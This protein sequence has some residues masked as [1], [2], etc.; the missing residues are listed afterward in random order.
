MFEIDI[1]INTCDN[2]QIKKNTILKDIPLS[3]ITKSYIHNLIQ[4]WLSLKQE[5]RL[6]MNN[7]NLNSHLR[8]FS[9]YTP[10]VG[11]PVQ[12]IWHI[13]LCVGVMH[14]LA[15]LSGGHRGLNA[16]PF[17]AAVFSWCWVCSRPLPTPCWESTHKWC[18][19][20]P[21][22]FSVT[23][24]ERLLNMSKRTFTQ[25]NVADLASHSSHTNSNNTLANQSLLVYL[26]NNSDYPYYIEIINVSSI[27]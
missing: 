13:L 18:I 23:T 6:P 9:S 11:V 16:P 20:L 5:T 14:L 8:H 1:N 27:E 12:S 10:V 2:Y 19:V 3:D 21:G 15:V 25:A 7:V 17:P 24:N 4:R 26:S 22:S